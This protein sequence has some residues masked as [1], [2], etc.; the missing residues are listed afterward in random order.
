MKLLFAFCMILIL[1]SCTTINKKW[2]VLESE[3]AYLYIADSLTSIVDKEI[4][5]G[6]TLFFE[7]SKGDFQKVYTRNP[8]SI[9][10]NKRS[11]YR[12]YLYRPKW[13]VIKHKYSKDTACITSVPIEE[14]RNYFLGERGGCYYINKNGNKTYVYRSY[15]DNQKKAIQPTIQ[16]ALKQPMSPTYTPK[17]SLD[18]PTVQCSGTTKKGDRCRNKTTNCSGR[19]HLH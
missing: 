11:T 8:K 13:S 18:C 9:S 5:S 7:K 17:P 3:S 4:Q 19:C 2:G 10:K 6:S 12:Y 16:P 1:H 14:T 15:C